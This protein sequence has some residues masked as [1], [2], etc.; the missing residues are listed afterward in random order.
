MITKA[1]QPA[2]GV[3][4]ADVKR[5]L[6]SRLWFGLTRPAAARR[7]APVAPRPVAS[8]DPPP[9]RASATPVEPPPRS[10]PVPIDALTALLDREPAGRARLRHLALLESSCRSSPA[11]P[12][13]RLPP[14]AA[15]IALRQLDAFLPRHP[16]LR[17]L[18]LQ[19]ERHL[20][21]HRARMAALLAAED[22]KWQPEILGPSPGPSLA[23]DS[24]IGGPW[25]VTDFQETLPLGASE[26]QDPR[27]HCPQEPIALPAVPAL[28]GHCG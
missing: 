23:P 20:Q 12:F 10:V 2:L 25:G 24:M 1:F 13:A 27:L 21:G 6:W 28:A 8:I 16:A 7:A 3:G 19:L 26:A 18:R 17:V 9:R 14:R 15:D 4:N 11:D 5:S 22:L